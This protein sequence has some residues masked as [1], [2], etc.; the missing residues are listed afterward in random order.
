[1]LPDEAI[2]I[3]VTA[4]TPRP[5]QPP[6]LLF[7]EMRHCGGAMRRN[8]AG[9]PNAQGRSGEIVLELCGLAFTPELGAAVESFMTT[10]RAALKPYVTGAVYLNFLEGEEKRSPSVQF[11]I[12]PLGE[13]EY[14][15]THDQVLGG[16][17]GQVYLGCGFPADEAY[18]LAAYTLLALSSRPSLYQGDELMQRGWKWN[19]NPKDH[20]TSPGDLNNA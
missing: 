18:R 6:L 14:V 17:G 1:M 12:D 2:D 3:V 7:A 8:A 9:K 11:R 10:V 4:A 15:S 13:I 20:P 19:G 16:P 5:E